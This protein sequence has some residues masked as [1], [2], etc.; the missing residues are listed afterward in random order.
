MPYSITLVS[1]PPG[2]GKSHRLQ[3]LQCEAGR[4]KPCLVLDSALPATVLHKQL[5][6]FEEGQEASCLVLDDLHNLNEE[7]GRLLADWVGEQ[8][9][10][11]K[12]L[13]SSGPNLKRVLFAVRSE[14]PLSPARPADGSWENFLSAFPMVEHVVVQPLRLP[15]TLGVLLDELE[16]DK[17]LL[18][19]AESIQ[20]A[21]WLQER[22]GGNPFL[23]L[24]LVR[25]ARER[26]HLVPGLHHSPFD[27]ADGIMGLRFQHLF[28]H[29]PQSRTMAGALHLT[30]GPL[31]VAL[32]NRLAPLGPEV[33]HTVKAWVQAGH[34][35][36]STETGELDWSHDL[37]RE[38]PLTWL[39]EPEQVELSLHLVELLT[40]AHP[41][42]LARLALKA[43]MLAPAER[44]PA[45]DEPL[46]QALMAW[47]GA[48]NAVGLD[49]FCFRL[50]DEPHLTWACREAA[51][52]ILCGREARQQHRPA[53]L[54]LLRR[55]E[56]E[57]LNAPE[58][59]HLV[60]SLAATLDH[61]NAMSES[62]AWLE[63]LD[64]VLEPPLRASLRLDLALN[65]LLKNDR[66][67]AATFV[68]GQPLRLWT[69]DPQRLAQLELLELFL[70]TDVVGNP[71]LWLEKL[72]RF[73]E[74]QGGQLDAWSLDRLL[75]Q[76]VDAAARARD[77]L[78]MDRWQE[79]AIASVR[80]VARHDPP[81]LG[82]ARVA[83]R[84]MFFGR[85][86]EGI[87]DLLAAADWYMA[88]GNLRMALPDLDAAATT[89]FK[90][91]EVAEALDLLKSVESLLLGAQLDFTTAAFRINA[92]APF[93]A[94]GDWPSAKRW[95]V[96]LDA[97]V[98]AQPAL[99]PFHEYALLQVL[100]RQGR[101]HPL[102]APDLALAWEMV[103]RQLALCPAGGIRQAELLALSWVFH[104]R[105]N[106][107]A[108]QVAELKAALG[109]L[110]GPNM[111]PR[112][113]AMTQLAEATQLFALRVGG[114]WNQVA[115]ELQDRLVACEAPRCEVLRSFQLARLAHL[116]GER[117]SVRDHVLRAALDAW[118]TR[119][120]AW[121]DAL[122][123]CFPKVRLEGL[124]ADHSRDH[125][126]P[127][128]RMAWLDLLAQQT[129]PGPRFRAFGID[130]SA[131][132][133]RQ[134]LQNQLE[135]VARELPRWRREMNPRES[136]VLDSLEQQV[137]A[138]AEQLPELPDHLSGDHGP[139]GLVVHLSGSL[140]LWLRGE[141]LPAERLGGGLFRELLVFLVLERWR[142]PG[143]PW[144]P[145]DLVRRLWGRTGDPTRQLNSLYVYISQL[146]NLLR[147][148][149]FPD[150]L[151]RSEGGYCLHR[152]CPVEL[153]LQQFQLALDQE[154]ISL[155]A[156]RDKKAR[157]RLL[158][159]AASCPRVL[160]PSLHGRW[161]DDLRAWHEQR[162]FTL[163]DRL[164]E[165]S[166]KP[167]ERKALQI[168]RRDFYPD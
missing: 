83:R 55:I 155:P 162:W 126:S 84:L 85:S 20:W 100:E 29:Y 22:S 72:E 127:S 65:R 26:G 114:E 73:H 5:I 51:L 30:G 95:L 110:V 71:A 45:L 19:S 112:P 119:Q 102:E 145:K 142:H 15:E 160:D 164:L 124:V 60:D 92:C 96:G 56:W 116:R 140:R 49:A 105:S 103:A 163:V 104:A 34:W 117:V 137:L 131:Q 40:A 42:T 58:R 66:K 113:D 129:R 76:I 50:L 167:M 9:A 25:A 31:P 144:S 75:L 86:H 33:D 53:W 130:L 147:Q 52:N 152:D 69:Q 27:H 61:C 168:M 122:G 141:E 48:E 135:R 32:M 2:I 87:P 94:G 151:D 118:R 3:H 161:L 99:R 106:G 98:E 156:L 120:P 64:P 97:I 80:E 136:V 166:R 4:H 18:A 24:Q 115:R 43:W 13:G 81:A 16:K 78:A 88:R 109:A 89:H 44:R 38:E 159:A 10:R 146:K 91:G 17:L 6:A 37:L 138:L 158:K 39:D 14:A 90:H 93:L 82:R 132:D 46:R 11:G 1:G 154:G 8:A 47:A 121:L 153:D 79:R 12:D 134:L 36:M 41:A 28:H 35:R 70:D 149:G 101:V 7:S 111:D 107:P 62:G 21:E 139:V 57:H 143:R 68:E 108:P 125:M 165:G 54:N 74:S 59:R 123:A 148:S 67:G 23:I 150:C 133:P 77:G 63:K 128:A 157:A